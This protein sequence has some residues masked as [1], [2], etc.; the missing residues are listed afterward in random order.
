MSDFKVTVAAT[1]LAAALIVMA[2]LISTAIAGET[3]SD[4]IT[5]VRDQLFEVGYDAEAGTFNYDA[6]EIVATDLLD[7]YGD[8]QAGSFCERYAAS[9]FFYASTFVE[10]ATSTVA[11]SARLDAAT[12]LYYEFDRLQA[13]CT[14]ED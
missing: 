5:E 13:A 8:T 2:G 14:Y 9:V 7:L 12:V 11:D 4:T 1:V 6:I 10:P 3:E